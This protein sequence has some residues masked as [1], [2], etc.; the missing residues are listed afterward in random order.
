MRLLEQNLI[1]LFQYLCKG[2]EN[3]RKNC[4]L[5]N[6]LFVDE[7]CICRNPHLETCVYEENTYY[8]EELKEKVM[9]EIERK[10]NFDEGFKRNMHQPC[11]KVGAY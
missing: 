11:Y 10:K 6:Y 3:S 5:G 2:D 9:R 7:K 1:Y 4:G 8:K